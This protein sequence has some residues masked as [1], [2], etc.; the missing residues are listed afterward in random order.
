MTG[1]FG[2]WQADQISV[3]LKAAQGLVASCSELLIE[4]WAVER[5]AA[6]LQFLDAMGT[7]KSGQ[8]LAAKFSKKAVGGEDSLEK[9]LNSHIQVVTE[10]RDFFQQCVDRYGEVDDSNASALASVDTPR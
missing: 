2:G 9:S 7:L 4:L 6:S 5:E 8:D 1:F 3:D 10:M